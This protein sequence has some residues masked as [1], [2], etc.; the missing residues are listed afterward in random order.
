MDEFNDTDM[1]TVIRHCGHIFHT[2]NIMNWF[3]SHCN[4][5]VC[6]YDIRD[7]NSNIT[8]QFFNNSQDSSSNN[9]ERN[10]TETVILNHTFG[11]GM[12]HGIGQNINDIENL[13]TNASG[14]FDASG[15]Y[16]NNSTDVLTS[17]L[18]NIL[19]RNQNAR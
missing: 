1:V 11:P 8:N 5:P 6:R 10:N 13:L 9:I 12:G 2:E 18:F 7:Y 3:S 16:T 14:I 17:F 15:N 19:N 4:C